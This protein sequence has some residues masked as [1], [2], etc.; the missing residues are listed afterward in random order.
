MSELFGVDSGRSRSTIY[1]ASYLLLPF[2]ALLS[3]TALNHSVFYQVN[4]WGGEWPGATFWI[5]LTNLGDGFFLFPLTMLLFYKKPDKQL[6]VILTMLVGAVLLNG[7]KALLPSLRPV[8]ALGLDAVNVLGP[9]LKTDTMPSGH[10]GT[11]FLLVG[12]SCLYL[13][14]QIRWLVLLFSSLTGLSRVV[15]GAH[16]PFD[17]FLGAWVGILS[18]VIGDYLASKMVSGLKSRV[19]FILLGLLCVAVLPFYDNGYRSEAPVLYFQFILSFLALV[20]CFR[21][22]V[23]LYKDELEAHLKK[24]G[25]LMN[26][27]FVLGQ[28]LTKFGMV[29]A[30]GFLV[31]MGVYTLLGQWFGVPHLLARGGSYW[32][33]ASWNWFWNR[34][35]TFSHVPKEKKLK[36]WS[37]YLSMCL[38]SFLPNWGTYYLL[39]TFIPFFMEYK[40]LALITGVMA[41][42]L[43]NFTIATVFVFAGRQSNI[44]KGANL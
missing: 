23:S 1:K 22:T 3:V 18:V 15:V 42:M 8:G 26:K 33:A 44:A 30:S 28:R 35:F 37:K 25:T 9:V 20:L 39:T 12:L 16:W 17:I 36:Q 34:T 4:S 40:Q 11:V 27:G 5:L 14:P 43:F 32:V 19:A 21:C 41:G 7:G 29:G 13:K 24:P 10:T 31:D 2:V 6:A 38:V